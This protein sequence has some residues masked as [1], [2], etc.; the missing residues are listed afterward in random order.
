LSGYEKQWQ[1][2]RPAIVTVVAETQWE[3]QGR[4]QPANSPLWS[5]LF[6]LQI[7]S[8]SQRAIKGEKKKERKKS[9][10]DYNFPESGT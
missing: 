10:C 5:N 1:E 3:K 6:G 7:E 8:G 2:F 4:A 9:N